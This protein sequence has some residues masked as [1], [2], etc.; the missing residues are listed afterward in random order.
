MISFQKKY[1]GNVKLKLY[2]IT[3]LQPGQD[4]FSHTNRLCSNSIDAIVSNAVFPA[5]KDSPSYKM[6]VKMHAPN[7]ESNIY[8]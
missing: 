3:W 1:F 4:V 2:A 6:D 5:M 7:I 8:M